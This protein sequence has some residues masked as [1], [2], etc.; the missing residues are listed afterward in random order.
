LHKNGIDNFHLYTLNRSAMTER[1][2][3]NFRDRLMSES[4]EQEKKAS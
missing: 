1:I 4:L 3:E 2:I